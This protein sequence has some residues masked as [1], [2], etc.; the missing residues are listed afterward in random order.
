[1]DTIGQGLTT[2][3]PCILQQHDYGNDADVGK[4]VLL[5]ETYELC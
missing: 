4:E 1:M 3:G 5:A 2:V